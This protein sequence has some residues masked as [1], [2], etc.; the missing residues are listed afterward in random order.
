[1][2]PNGARL[3]VGSAIAAPD[4][5]RA[6]CARNRD[7]C[8]E[9]ADDDLRGRVEATGASGAPRAPARSEARE[10]D[11]FEAMLI[12]RTARIDFDAAQA[13]PEMILTPARLGELRRVNREV[14]RAIAP[15]TDRLAY[16]LEEYWATPISLSTGGPLRGDCEDYALEKRAAL[17]ALG[18]SPEA[19]SLAVAHAP[20]VGLHAVLIVQTH[21][22]DYVLDNLYREPQPLDRVPYHWISR[23]TGASLSNWA[24]AHRIDVAAGAP[25]LGFEAMMRERMRQVRAEQGEAQNLQIGQAELAAPVAHAALAQA[26]RAAKGKHLEPVA[27]PAPPAPLEAADQ[28][29]SR[30]RAPRLARHATS[31][32]KG[33]ARLDAVAR[34]AGA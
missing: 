11:V 23:Q 24:T 13:R 27:P 19:L 29:L 4:G 26:P 33:F 22:G 30:E 6:F 32:V 10:I 3:V 21:A 34:A 7:Q 1:M 5:A 18:W 8:V 20:G 2:A 15:M 16:G 14:N 17:I 25:G 31:A 28:S 9:G 12:A